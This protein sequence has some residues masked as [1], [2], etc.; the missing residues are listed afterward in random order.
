MGAGYAFAMAQWL[1]RVDPETLELARGAAKAI[2]PETVALVR[3]AARA[4]GTVETGAASRAAAIMR[5][6]QARQAVDFA[7]VSEAVRRFNAVS[8]SI[9]TIKRENTFV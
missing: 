3:D 4:A 7:A 2:N 9:D 6:L 8:E 1:P 5:D